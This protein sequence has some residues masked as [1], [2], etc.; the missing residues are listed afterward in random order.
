MF[1]WSMNVLLGQSQSLSSTLILVTALH[2]AILLVCSGYSLESFYKIQSLLHS[3]SQQVFKR[4]V[5]PHE[6]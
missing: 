4:V 6:L 3:I 1:D 5:S 2:V